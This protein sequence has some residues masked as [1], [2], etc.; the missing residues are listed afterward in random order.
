MVT[1]P[2]PP[3]ASF[4]EAEKPVDDFVLL[5]NDS[6]EVNHIDAVNH[7][8]R[9]NPTNYKKG[10]DYILLKHFA[11]GII[12]KEGERWKKTKQA[13]APFF[14]G[15]KLTSY[16]PTISDVT[17]NCLSDIKARVLRGDKIDILTELTTL[18]FKVIGKTLFDCDFSELAKEAVPKFREYWKLPHFS[19]T[20]LLDFLSH[21]FVALKRQ[22]IRYELKHLFINHLKKYADQYPEIIESLKQKFP[23]ENWVDYIWPEYLGLS[24]VGTETSAV[25]IAWALTMLGNHHEAQNKLRASFESE[26]LEEEPTYLTKFICETLR[27]YPPVYEVSRQALSNDTIMGEEFRAGTVFRIPILRFHRSPKY[28]ENPAEFNPERFSENWPPSP[29]FMPFGAGPRAC[30]GENMAFQ[31]MEIVIKQFVQH[32][33]IFAEP[34]LNDTFEEECPTLRTTD[35]F[36]VSLKIREAS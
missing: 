21:P 5:N 25:A 26:N 13:I 23:G 8:L 34:V 30:L 12:S 4:S 35:S 9:N 7:I 36:N 22:L 3:L 20:L 14:R 16:R 24:T 10:P 33:D 11:D 1:A 2:T 28:W 17:E 6:I 31:E 27:M 18:T 32:F 29:Y 19:G 15:E